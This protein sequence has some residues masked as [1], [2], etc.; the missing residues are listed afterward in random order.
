MNMYEWMIIKHEIRDE[1]YA[2]II[3]GKFETVAVSAAKNNNGP[4]ILV[5]YK[6]SG[7]FKLKG[8]FPTWRFALKNSTKRKTC[9]KMCRSLNIIIVLFSSPQYR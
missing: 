3:L 8:L 2:Q 6:Y 9:M 1:F 4:W 7:Y 5:F